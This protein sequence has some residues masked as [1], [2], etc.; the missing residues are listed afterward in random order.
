VRAQRPVWIVVLLVAASLVELVHAGGWWGWGRLQ[1]GLEADAESGARALADTS[2]FALPSTAFWSRRL[3]GSLLSGAEMETVTEV[4]YTVGTHQQR[5]LP[6]D[7]EGSENTARA[8]ILEGDLDSA[9]SALERALIRDPTSPYLHRLTAVLLR[10]TGR[11]D[12][13]LDHMATAAGIAPGYSKPT[14]ELTPEDEL[15]IRRKGLRRPSTSTRGPVSRACS[16]LPRSCVDRESGRRHCS[17]W[18]RSKGI[19]M[20]S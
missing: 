5:W 15:W 6:S 19:Q 12:E 11:P 9:V 18:Q 8:A 3:V 7:P 16:P 14:V 1:S 13:F 10:Q 4:F 20:C 2:W 17:R